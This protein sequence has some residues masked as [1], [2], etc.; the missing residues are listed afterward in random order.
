MD[1]AFLAEVP[2]F[3]LQ[4]KRNFDVLMKDV[5]LSKLDKRRIECFKHIG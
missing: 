2:L 5:I 3:K 4:N 1:V